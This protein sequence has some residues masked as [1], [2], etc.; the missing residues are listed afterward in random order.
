MLL[1]IIL[2]I[3]WYSLHQTLTTNNYYLPLKHV[4]ESNATVL[5]TI[6]QPSSEVFQLFD[7][8]IFMK[9]GLIF[10]QGPVSEIIPYFS[11]F[12]LANCLWCLSKFLW[13][14]VSVAF[15][16]I[17][18]ITHICFKFYF[19]YECPNN[20]N[21]ADFVMLLSQTETQEVLAEKGMFQ[22]CGER[23]GPLSG[24]YRQMNLQQYTYTPIIDLIS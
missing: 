17:F 6:H 4:A 20:Y 9:D 7:L 24:W 8:V 12:G 16:S 3:S 15:P 13:T 5:C 21:P 19:R 18:M 23:V 11:K 14:A 10:F 22:L 2:I 1:L